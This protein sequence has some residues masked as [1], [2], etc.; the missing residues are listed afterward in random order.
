MS[1]LPQGYPHNLHFQA[2]QW[3][4]NVWHP[5]SLALWLESHILLALQL[6]PPDIPKYTLLRTRVANVGSAPVLMSW[7]QPGRFKIVAASWGELMAVLEG[8]P[9]CLWNLNKHNSGVWRLSTTSLCK[10]SLRSRRWTSPEEWVNVR[11]SA[12]GPMWDRLA[13][14]GRTMH[15]THVSSCRWG[16][17]RGQMSGRCTEEPEIRRQTSPPTR[18]RASSLK[19]VR[20]A[21]V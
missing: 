13:G 16:E 17:S 6:F 18:K 5:V 2:W 7:C 19:S 9:V 15:E 11:G 1:F 14:E 12:W 21:C 8:D 3:Q 10:S 20:E 4:Q